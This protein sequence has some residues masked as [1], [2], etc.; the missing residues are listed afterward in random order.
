MEFFILILLIFLRGLPSDFFD[1]ASKRP[2]SGLALGGYGSSSED[3]EDEE[4]SA[5]A[6]GHNSEN[7]AKPVVEGLPA[8]DCDEKQFVTKLEGYMLKA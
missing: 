8:G 4:D 1:S 6:P 2:A 7:A 3:E 5:P